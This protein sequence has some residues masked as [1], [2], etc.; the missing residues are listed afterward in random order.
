KSATEAGFNR[1]LSSILDSN[2]TTVIAAIVLYSLGSGT[3]KGFALTLMIGIVLSIFTA[4]TVTKLLIKLG[5]E[6]GLLNTSSH[7]GVKRG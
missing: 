6:M 7:F 1:A 3:V 4:L 2:I 5:M